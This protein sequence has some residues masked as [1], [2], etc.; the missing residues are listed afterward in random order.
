MYFNKDKVLKLGS[1]T[2]YKIEKCKSCEL[3]YLCAAGCP[4][5]LLGSDNE[6]HQPVCGLY[7]IDEFWNRLEELI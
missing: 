4:L 5:P 3:R 2:I 1:R 6:I 7:G